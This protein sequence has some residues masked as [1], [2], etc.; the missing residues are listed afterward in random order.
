MKQKRTSI[1]R[2]FLAVLPALLLALVLRPGVAL[3]EDTYTVTYYMS[4]RI[5]DVEGHEGVTNFTE[6]VTA[7]K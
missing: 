2:V 7:G 5:F 1:F 3:A 4:D 6:T